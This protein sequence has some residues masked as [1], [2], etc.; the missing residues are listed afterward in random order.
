MKA[1]HSL[2]LTNQTQVSRT[3]AIKKGKSPS[4]VESKSNEVNAA[5][6][7]EMWPSGFTLIELLVVIAI[8]AILASLLLPVLGKAKTKAQGIACLNNMRQLGLCWTMYSDDYSDW[9]VPNQGDTHLDTVPTPS[10][11]NRDVLWLQ[12]RT[13][14]RK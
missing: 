1:I 13:T 14:G 4:L 10:A 3:R 11:G 2:S 5:I 6:Y 8:I 12:E 7:G 9:V